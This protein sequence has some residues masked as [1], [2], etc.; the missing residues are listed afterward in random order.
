MLNGK[1]LKALRATETAGNRVAVAIEAA[2]LTQME[3]ANALGMP[4]PYVSDV[5]RN[6]YQTITV[7]NARKFA[8][9]FGCSIEDLFPARD[10]ERQAVGQ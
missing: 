8:E 3:V 4:Q 6:R 10:D 2:G 5:V 1:Q 7:D 9:F